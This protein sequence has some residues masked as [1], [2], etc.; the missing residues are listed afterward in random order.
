ML[1]FFDNSAVMALCASKST[2]SFD[3]I[4]QILAIETLNTA[5]ISR[6]EGGGLPC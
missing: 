1:A 6:C 4:G 2:P 5:Y 3:R